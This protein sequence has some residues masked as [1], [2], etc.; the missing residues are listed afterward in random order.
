MQLTWSLDAP[1][2][3]AWIATMYS[4]HSCKLARNA[5]ACSMHGPN[6]LSQLD[7]RLS[8]RIEALAAAAAAAALVT[9]STCPAPFDTKSHSQLESFSDSTHAHKLFL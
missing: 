4:N 2:C 6:L 3:T 5:T 8:R 7:P 1:I 9:A